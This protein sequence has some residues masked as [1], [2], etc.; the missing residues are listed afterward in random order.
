MGAG[1]HGSSVT[2]RDRVLLIGLLISLLNGLLNTGSAWG[3]PAAGTEEGRDPV[4]V[5]RELRLRGALYEADAAA[6]TALADA[7]ADPDLQFELYLEMAKIFDRFGLHRNTRPVAASLEAIAAAESVDRHSNTRTRGA[8]ELA[9]ADYYYR[10]EL[11]ERE[12]PIALAHANEAIRLLTKADE[13]RLLADAVHRRGL[14]HMQRRELDEAHRW[15]DRSLEIDQSA[16]AREFFLGEYHRHVGFVHYLR[17]DIAESIPH[18]RKSLEFRRRSGAIDASLF[19]AISLGTALVETSSP[20]EAQ[21][22]LLYALMIA[23]RIDSPAGRARAAIALGAMYEALENPISARAAYELCVRTA[24][25]IAMESLDQRA[26]EAL[27]RLALASEP[28]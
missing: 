8:I 7:A 12:F 21:E 26:T 23:D 19:A 24:R 15:F 6:R 14:I 5:I 11:S 20:E 18:Q 4:E 1:E 25:V 17:G 3:T 16:G 22:P 13:Q 2:R 10:A 9:K 28:R 27:E